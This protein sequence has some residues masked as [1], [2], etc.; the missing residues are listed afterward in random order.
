MSRW[1]DF[2]DKVTGTPRDALDSFMDKPLETLG[3]DI[4]TGG[5]ISGAVGLGAIS[6]FK[7]GTNLLQGESESGNPNLTL[8]MPDMSDINSKLVN[9]AY[10]DLIGNIALTKPSYAAKVDTIPNRAYFVKDIIA[11]EARLDALGA[12]TPFVGSDQLITDYRP[13]L[14]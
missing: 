6:D 4:L 9:K 5:L 2:R 12:L 3:L 13:K 1:T 7:L 8:N 10:D 14:N 11:D